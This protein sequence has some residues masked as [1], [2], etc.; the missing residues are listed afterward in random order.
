[1]L[2]AAEASYERQKDLIGR[3]VS[4]QAQYDQALASRDSAQSTLDQAKVNTNLA[5]INNDYAHVA[6]PFHG[7][8]TAREVWV[9][10]YV[11]GSGPPT[12]LATIVQLDPI[13]VNFTASER[14]VLRVR[15]LLYKRNQR[16]SDLLGT[17]VD[18]AL[19][20]D[21]GYPHKGKLD[22]I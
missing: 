9:G 6:A 19:Q 12:Q 7:V 10:E 18:V 1:S 22:Y 5:V 17:E 2:K 15:D 8:V 14:D 11:G 16:A 20:T 21:T 4:T 13:W 3:Q